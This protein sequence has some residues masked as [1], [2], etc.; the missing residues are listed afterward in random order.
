MIF[1]LRPE[2]AEKCALRDLRRSEARPIHSKSVSVYPNQNFEHLIWAGPRL[3]TPSKQ[4]GR[5]AGSRCGRQEY[6]VQ[7]VST[8]LSSC[9]VGC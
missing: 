8:A 4:A 5:Q 3:G 7:A 1:L 6:M 2:E 9:S